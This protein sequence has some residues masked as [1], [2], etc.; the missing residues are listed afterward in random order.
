MKIVPRLRSWV[1][2]GLNRSR[3]ERDMDDELSF[4]VDRDIEDLVRQGLTSAEAKRRARV[5]CGAI[6]AR[7]D[8]MREALGLRLLDERTD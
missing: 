8:E 4:H 7:K 2:N 5:E 3:L 1:R 6:E